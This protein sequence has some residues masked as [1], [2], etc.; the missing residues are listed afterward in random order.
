VAR[1]EQVDANVFAAAQQIAGGFF[2]LGRNVNR[3]ERSGAIEDG[4]LPGIA[5]VA[6]P[7]DKNTMNRPPRSTRQ[8]FITRPLLFQ[9]A[10]VCSIYTAIALAVQGYGVANKLHWQTMVFTILSVGQLMLAIA[11]RADKSSFFKLNLFGNPLML[12]VVGLTLAIQLMIIYMPFFNGLLKTEPL[13]GFEL[14][15]CLAVSVLIIPL[16]EL[17][18]LFRRQPK[19]KISS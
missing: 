7:A 3:R 14:I 4:E 15:I 2:L 5:L 19:V 13:T 1:P 6:E 10:W 16:V 8:G 9:I 18:K 17:E 11:V 12:I